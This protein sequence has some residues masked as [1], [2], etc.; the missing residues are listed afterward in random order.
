MQK[1]SHAKHHQHTA[2]DRSPI[3]LHHEDHESALR[4]TAAVEDVQE[5][6]EAVKQPSGSPSQTGPLQVASAPE[7]LNP[8]TPAETASILSSH[9]RKDVLEELK[10]RVH[11]ASDDDLENVPETKWRIKPFAAEESITLLQ[12]PQKA[13]GKTTLMLHAIKEAAETGRFLDEPCSPAPVMYLTEQTAATFLPTLKQIGLLGRPDFH[14][15]YWHDAAGISW[16]DLVYGIGELCREEGVGLLVV[17]T[18]AQFA[19][20][21]GDSENDSGSILKAINP[22]REIAATGLSIVIIHHERKA[23]GEIWNAGRGSGALQGGCDIILSLRRTEGNTRS[24]LRQI[25][26]IGRLPGIPEELIVEL[27]E[28]GYISHGTRKDVVTQ[29]AQALALEV[30]PGSEENALAA[31]ELLAAAQELDPK[32]GR[33]TFMNAL[34]TLSEEGSLTRIGEGVKGDAFRYFRP[35]WFIHPEPPL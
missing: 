26:A 12:G 9:I 23:S 20:L 34:K 8:E 25:Q 10:K 29:G 2:P 22:L 5:Q 28:T 14:F 7:A 33:T 13:A 6:P 30:A 16:R 27:T 31:D 24:T 21:G 18:F 1:S 3:P 11:R 15:L 4:E 32:V 19:G 35:D 17:D